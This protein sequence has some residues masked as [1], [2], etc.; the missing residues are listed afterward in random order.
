MKTAQ[1]LFPN[2]LTGFLV[3]LGVGLL[4]YPQAAAWF[5]QLN[6]TE[7]TV[8]YNKA[9]EN[10]VPNAREQLA[11]ARAYNDAL[12]TGTLIPAN[13]RLPRL[14]G[15]SSDTVE[16]N[17]RTWTY[18]ELLSTKGSPIM[19]RLRIPKIDV[20]LP[21]Y[22]GTSDETL[23]KGAGH[24]EGTALPVG[25]ASTRSVI[26]AHR[27]L[28]EATMFTNL[29][30]VEPGDRFTVEVFGEVLTYEVRDVVVVEPEETEHLSVEAGR[31]LVTL[32]TCTPL[33]I[34]SHRI[35]VTGS[36]WCRRRRR[37][38][39]R[40]AR[41][42]TCRDSRSGRSSGRSLFSS[43]PWLSATAPTV[44]FRVIRRDGLTSMALTKRG[45]RKSC[46]YPKYRAIRR[47]KASRTTRYLN[48]QLY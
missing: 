33:G 9:I 23:L 45:Y 24:L 27:G 17:G 18:E 11:A 22:H 44:R 8:E 19:A 13:E 7:L 12:T 5:A 48:K 14:A 16:V 3:L 34:N 21:V 40:R 6:Q 31:D 42:L 4:I 25:G 10:A 30:K 38:W 15:E 47:V 46:G 43:S 36:G 20:D 37:I 41:N 26:T 35:L 28:A 39:R 29:D 32:V 2:Y 1:R